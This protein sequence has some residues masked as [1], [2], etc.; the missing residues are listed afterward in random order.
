MNPKYARVL[1]QNNW[2]RLD[3][4]WI[5]FGEKPFDDREIGLLWEIGY[6]ENRTVY[7]PGNRYRYDAVAPED[8]K[9]TVYASKGLDGQPW[10]QS[11]Y[12]NEAATVEE[13][14]AWVEKKARNMARGYRREHD[15]HQG[16]K[17]AEAER[18]AWLAANAPA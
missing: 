2:W 18:R 3:G 9:F 8:R 5:G 7:L 16:L 13:L 1:P 10:Q 17:K 4:G 12:S 11:H 14:R 6:F 15:Y